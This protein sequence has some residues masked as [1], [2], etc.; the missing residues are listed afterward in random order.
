MSKFIN[1]I[2]LLELL[3]SRNMEVLRIQRTKIMDKRLSYFYN[4]GLMDRQWYLTE[5]ERGVLNEFRQFANR[6]HG[7]GL[8]E[9]SFNLG[10][11]RIVLGK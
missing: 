6:N 7:P 2:R 10:F 11:V 4:A 5:R 9:I 1:R 3:D 8:K